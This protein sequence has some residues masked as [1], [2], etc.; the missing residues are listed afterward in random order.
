MT[1]RGRGE[2]NQPLMDEKWLK[3]ARILYL[4]DSEEKG[5]TKKKR[6]EER[7]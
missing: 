6:K 5:N 7:F 4:T 3:K 1:E 2:K